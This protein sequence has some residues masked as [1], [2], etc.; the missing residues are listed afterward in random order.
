M[1]LK[2][3]LSVIHL[4]FTALASLALCQSVSAADSSLSWESQFRFSIV[5][6]ADFT[7]G[8]NL[9]DDVSSLDFRLRAVAS[10]PAGANVLLRIGGDFEQIRF[11]APASAVIPDELQIASL[12]L[13]ADIQAGEAWIIRLEIQPGFY[14]GGTSLRSEDFNVPITLGASYFVSADLQLVAGVSVDVN[15]KCPVLPGVGLRWKLASDW[16]LN[17]ILPNPRLEY[18]VNDSVLLYAGADVRFGSFRTEEDFGRIRHD[19]SLNEAVVEYTQIRAG[20]GASWKIS[21]AATIEVEAGFVPVNELNYH[22]AEFRMRSEDLPPY[23]GINV[24][25]KF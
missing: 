7:D 21:P 22:R 14:S 12:V 10:L 25:L 18:S 3:R 13:G 2:R 23:G 19:N 20:L 9:R 4:A 24:R 17:G 1:R 5:G 15:R 16:V 6:D 8:S 11:D